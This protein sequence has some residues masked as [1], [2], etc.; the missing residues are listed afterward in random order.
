[1]QVETNIVIFEVTGEKKASYYVEA[2]KR[3]GV[4]TVATSPA[5]IRMVTHLDVSEEDIV[6]TRNAINK[7]K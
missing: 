7:V 5:T 3:E 4:S 2:L 1:M 6:K